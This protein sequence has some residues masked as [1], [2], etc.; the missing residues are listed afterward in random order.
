MGEEGQAEPRLYV[1]Q[2]QAGTGVLE[3]RY[4]QE[5]CTGL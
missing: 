4:K 5:V 3:H 2:R 1:L